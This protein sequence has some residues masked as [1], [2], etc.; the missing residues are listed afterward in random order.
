MIFEKCLVF[1]APH[2][3]LAIFKPVVGDFYEHFFEPG[4]FRQSR[5]AGIDE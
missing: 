4:V 5:W 1:G 3:I 2:N